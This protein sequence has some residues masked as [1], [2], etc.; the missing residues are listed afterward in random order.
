ML[1]YRLC[2]IQEL[3]EMTTTYSSLGHSHIE[4]IETLHNRFQ[5]LVTGMRKKPYDILEYRKT[6]FSTD[7]EE[8][9]RQTA[10]IKVCC[11]YIRFQHCVRFYLEFMHSDATMYCISD[12]LN[13]LGVN[14]IIIF[15]LTR[16]K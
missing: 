1:V 12:K 10:D 7:F 14:V 8:F 2:K 6:E 15:V 9:K 5:L 11:M 3:L 4:G 13:V 16:T